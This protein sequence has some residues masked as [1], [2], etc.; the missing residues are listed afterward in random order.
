[1][2]TTLS[3]GIG[4]AVQWLKEGKKIRRHSWEPGIWI[5]LIKTNWG[6][7][8]DGNSPDKALY[9]FCSFENLLAEDWEIANER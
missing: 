1:M 3:E 6:M 9:T 7:H 5:H 2:T 8:L 4:T